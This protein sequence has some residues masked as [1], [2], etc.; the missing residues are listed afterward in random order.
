MGGFEVRGGRPEEYML[1]ESGEYA[2][3]ADADVRAVHALEKGSGAASVAT[4]VFVRRCAGYAVKPEAAALGKGIRT[5]GRDEPGRHAA[6]TWLREADQW[7]ILEGWWEDL[8][9]MQDLV[10]CM[11]VLGCRREDGELVRAL[12]AV[13]R[14]CDGADAACP[15]HSPAKREIHAIAFPPVACP[16]MHNELFRQA[17]RREE[18]P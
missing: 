17:G 4:R 12:N 15:D 10:R 9:T 16:A 3:R 8:Y 11:H 18:Y 1:G 5:G 14:R 7:E 13:A 6:E 2:G